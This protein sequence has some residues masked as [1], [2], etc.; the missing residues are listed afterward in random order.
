MGLGLTPRCYTPSGIDQRQIEL[1]SHCVDPRSTPPPNFYSDSP[2]KLNCILSIFFYK[3][4]LESIRESQRRSREAARR[5]QSGGVILGESSTK[6]QQA[7]DLLRRNGEFERTL[8]ENANSLSDLDI[9]V[10]RINSGIVDLNEKVKFMF[11]HFHQSCI[12]L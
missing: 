3:G 7:E 2:P 5:V 10:D 1:N 11:Q 4:A 6:R 9:R 12:L 8:R